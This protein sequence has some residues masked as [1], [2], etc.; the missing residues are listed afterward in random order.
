MPVKQNIH[1]M[2]HWL[3]KLEDLSSFESNDVLPQ[4]LQVDLTLTWIHPAATIASQIWC[5]SIFSQNI[6][7][8]RHW[9][10]LIVAV[11]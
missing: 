7:G 1:C 9:K 4:S 5:H 2:W 6:S 8:Q 10:L 3:N 11:E